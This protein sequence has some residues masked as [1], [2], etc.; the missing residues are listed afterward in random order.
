MIALRVTGLALLPIVVACTPMQW[1]KADGSPEQLSQDAAQCQQEAWREAR[2]R[3]F[4]YR[5]FGSTVFHDRYGRRFIGWP[6]G[7]FGDPFG[8]EFMEEQ[9]L[10]Q[11]CMRAKG[12]EL[13]PADRIQPSPGGTREGKP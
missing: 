6:Y 11:F 1:V 4:M 9:R 10:A 12:Y 2:W 7:P 8:D 3:S 13:V 5:P